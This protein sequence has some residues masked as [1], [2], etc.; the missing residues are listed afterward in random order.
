MA[1]KDDDAKELQNLATDDFLYFYLR[2]RK[3]RIRSVVQTMRTRFPQ[4]T[5]EELARR[6]VASH[7]QISA[8]GGGLVQMPLLI[9]GLGTALKYLGFVGGLSAF[10]RA[11]IYMILEIALV[12]DKDIDD[13][14]R[15]PEIAAV[16]AGCAAATATPSLL[17]DVLGIEPLFALPV[18]LMTAAGLTKTVGDRAIELY[19][20]ATRQEI[21]LA[22]AVPLPN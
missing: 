14:A 7:L 4:D 11:H 22:D 2:L 16:V 10:A 12:F 13:Q 18:A 15:I 3:S 6:I 8:L 5:R 21:D 17:A 9:P 19:S 1:A 20:K